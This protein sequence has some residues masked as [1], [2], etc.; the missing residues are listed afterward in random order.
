MSPSGGIWLIVGWFRSAYI[1]FGPTLGFV[2]LVSLDLES[3]QTLI[4]ITTHNFWYMFGLCKL[5][6]DYLAQINLAKF[7]S[8]NTHIQRINPYTLRIRHIF[9]TLHLFLAKFLMTNRDIIA[10]YVQIKVIICEKTCFFELLWIWGY[11]VFSKKF[12]NWISSIIRC[13]NCV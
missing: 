10:K 6:P 3:N 2:C 13:Q 5:N 8:A 9:L 1:F 4:N 12:V 7:E 11:F